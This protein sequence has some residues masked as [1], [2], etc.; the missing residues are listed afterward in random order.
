MP[1]DRRPR[2]SIHAAPGAQPLR[3]G[4]LALTHIH[5][6]RGIQQVHPRSTRDHTQRH[7]PLP[8]CLTCA[9]TSPVSYVPIQNRAPVPDLARQRWAPRPRFDPM[10]AP[11][12]PPCAATA[13]REL[14]LKHPG[15]PFSGAVRCLRV[16]SR[17]GEWI[18]HAPEPRPNTRRT[19]VATPRAPPGHT[20]AV[21]GRLARP[22]THPRCPAA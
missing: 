12:L 16:N 22:A 9:R 8:S 3:N 17:R 21:P 10:V 19:T 14:T 1:I 18:D 15:G 20:P 13:F 11:D 6:Q 5:A 2:V 4:S 7:T